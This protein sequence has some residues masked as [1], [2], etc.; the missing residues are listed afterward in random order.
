MPGSATSTTKSETGVLKA[1]VSLRFMG[2]GL[3]PG[4]I[5]AILGIPPTIAY[6]KGEVYRRSRDGTKEARGRTGLWLLSTR[7]HVEGADLGRHLSY[8]LGV[9]FPPG[10][11]KRLDRLRALMLA[12]GLAA[13]IGC[14][15]YGRRGAQPPIIP[16]Q[17]RE[18]FALLPARIETDFDT[19]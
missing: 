2:D 17:V 19:D 6:R 11:D 9:L 14:F 7:E 15:W 12:K 13:D 4:E 1:Y 16:E 3:D 10:G 5:T 8:L 18:A